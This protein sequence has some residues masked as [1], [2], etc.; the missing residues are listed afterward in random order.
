MPREEVVLHINTDFL[1][2]EKGITIE[3]VLLAGLAAIKHKYFAAYLSGA[4]VRAED[5]LDLAIDKA[6]KKVV[7]PSWRR[8][9]S[10]AT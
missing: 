7:R 10:S 1:K 4:D 2:G 5:R 8:R 9:T 6:C 3:M